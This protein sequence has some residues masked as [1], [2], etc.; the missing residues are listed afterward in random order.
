MGFPKG[1]SH[2]AEEGGEGLLLP[3]RN[4]YPVGLDHPSAGAVGYGSPNSLI[5]SVLA[6]VRQ[7][8]ESRT[9]QEREA[10]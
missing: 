4:G 2:R 5:F 8:G 7:H 1:T 9:P 10:A 3:R 6:V